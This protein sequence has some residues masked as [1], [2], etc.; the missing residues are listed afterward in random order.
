[1]A[2]VIKLRK[3]LNIH[4]KGTAAETKRVVGPCAE[5]V[6]R[7][8]SFEGVTP[9]IVV[10]EGDRVEVGDALFVDKNYPEVKF[11]SPI[12]GTVEA[13][14]AKFLVLNCKPTKCRNTTILGNAMWLRFLLMR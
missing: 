14:G 3:G 1:M 13:K 6:V 12:S 11:A 7:P 8:D 4:L 5:Y 9:K 2:N 10:H